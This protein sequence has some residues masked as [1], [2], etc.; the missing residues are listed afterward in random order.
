[1]PKTHTYFVRV[2]LGFFA[3]VAVLILIA[4]VDWLVMHPKLPEFKV[5]SAT[6]P[7][8]D[9]SRSELTATWDISILA[10]NPSQK[11]RIHYDHVDASIVY[12]DRNYIRVGRTSLRPFVV[13]TRNQTRVDMKLVAVSEWVGDD[14][15]NEIS[16]ERSRG[17][18]SFGVRL[19]TSVRFKCGLWLSKSRL[20][21]ITCDRVDFGF[22]PNNGIG[23][24]TGQWRECRVNL[25]SL[26]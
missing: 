19:M 16:D 4:F 3:C 12:G 24:L 8:L 18:V 15:A 1:M 11:F 5:E 10:I 26:F 25:N 2:L 23:T 22:S 13:N 7:Q 17:L 21:L 9:L 20:M 6:V 14:V